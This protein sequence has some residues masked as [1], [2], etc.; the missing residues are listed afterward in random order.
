MNTDCPLHAVLR[1]QS[2]ALVPWP[3]ASV[4]REPW[5]PW[6]STGLAGDSVR[7]QL[8]ERPLGHRRPRLP[9]GLSGPHGQD[10][11]INIDGPRRAGPWAGACSCG[12]CSARAA[13]RPRRERRRKAAGPQ[14]TALPAHRRGMRVRG[15]SVLRVPR[16]CTAIRIRVL[17]IP[18]QG[19]GC[20]AFSGSGREP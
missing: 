6:V 20:W 16:S 8:G 4:G 13:R 10:D 19:L 18:A 15:E 14:D 2:D 5:R 1:P 7:G 11:C 3:R 9:K 17:P 12:L